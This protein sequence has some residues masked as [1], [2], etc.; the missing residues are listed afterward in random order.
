VDESGALFGRAHPLLD[1]SQQ[2]AHSL[3]W[4]A[5]FPEA[6]S[7][8]AVSDAAMRQQRGPHQRQKITGEAQMSD[9]TRPENVSRRTILIAAVGAA[10]L[11]TLGATDANAAKLAQSA[12]KYQASPKDG[13]QCDGCNLFVAPNACKSVAGDIAPTGWCAL[14]V[15]K[16]A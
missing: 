10:P 13:K 15:K 16:A 8:P 1:L 14:W 5:L 4:A 9:Q 6:V 11:L 2:P 3:W 12:V 7:A